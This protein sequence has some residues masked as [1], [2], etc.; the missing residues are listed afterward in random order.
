[1]AHHRQA[2]GQVL[3]VH[4]CLKPANTP[5]CRLCPAFH[6]TGN[7]HLERRS[8]VP[9]VR[10]RLSQ[11]P[12]F[13]ATLCAAQSGESS[14]PRPLGPRVCS[15]QKPV[16]CLLFPLLPQRFRSPVEMQLLP[17]MGRRADTLWGVRGHRVQGRHPLGGTAS[18][19]KLF[20][21][22]RKEPTDLCSPQGSLPAGRA[23]RPRGGRG[24]GRPRRPSL[25]LANGGF[26]GKPQ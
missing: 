3:S 11:G 24:G 4:C 17:S 13:A 18:G 8:L 14:L 12:R 1:M 26:P 7:C 19:L 2:L 5:R 23:A 16:P 25:F 6:F 15:P 22:A 10:T 20:L 9:T 21:L